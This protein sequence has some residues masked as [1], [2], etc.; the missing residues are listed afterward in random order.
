MQRDGEQLGTV[1]IYIGV[2]VG[3][4]TSVGPTRHK[5]VA[6]YRQFG[7]TK[8]EANKQA[9]GFAKANKILAQ[10]I[11]RVEWTVREVLRDWLEY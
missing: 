6:V 5:E 1:V 11:T 9:N 10:A 7:V 2:I 3:P 4:L 8:E